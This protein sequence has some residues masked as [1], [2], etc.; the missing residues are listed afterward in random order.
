MGLI[1][2]LSRPK[3]PSVE[4]ELPAGGSLYATAL[5][6]TLTNPMTIMAFGAVFAS[7]GLATDSTAGAGIIATLGVGLGSLFW[8]V[9]LTTVVS[10]LHHALDARALGWVR[11]A[12]GLVIT[13]FGV[14]AVV[15]AI[16]GR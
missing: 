13:L 8:W 9:T 5:G 12:S 3:D 6:L 15:S 1:S 10:R 11:R 7:A 16:A 14:Y 4:P 2:L